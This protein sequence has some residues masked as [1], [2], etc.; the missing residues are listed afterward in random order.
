MH[1]VLVDVISVQAED[2]LWQHILVV[3]FLEFNR[4]QDQVADF[5]SK[6]LGLEFWIF[7]QNCQQ[8]VDA[9]GQVQ[10][11]ILSDPVQ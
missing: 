2:T 8:Q 9:K 4:L 11:F 5:F 7:V 6:F 10:I 1:D 3:F